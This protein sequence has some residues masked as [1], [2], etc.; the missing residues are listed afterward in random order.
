MKT[1]PS[2][3]FTAA[4]LACLTLT[5]AALGQGAAV[6]MDPS[7]T[8]KPEKVILSAGHGAELEFYRS[9]WQAMKV[10]TPAGKEINVTDLFFYTTQV[11][12][13]PD[14]SAYWTDPER[15]DKELTFRSGTAGGD[16]AA[17]EITG[18]RGPL[19]KSVN[20]AIYPDDPAVYVVSRLSAGEAVQI[21]GDPQLAYFGL[22][23]QDLRSPTDVFVDGENKTHIFD[24]EVTARGKSFLYTYFPGL[25]MCLAIL[26]LPKEKQSIRVDSPL[27]YLNRLGN[28]G[29]WGRE[30]R[31]FG[32]GGHELKPGEEIDLRYVIYWNDGD[33]LDEVKSLAGRLQSGALDDKFPETVGGN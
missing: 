23:P 14:L 28:R 29:D 5:Q 30:F 24:E 10:R 21:E 27:E 18:Q 7:G 31:V 8:D 16:G 25:D 13:D 32:L 9:L 3:G 2:T 4:L 20:A 33:R 11:T 22:P 19:N 17:V 26:A 15:W 12:E 1:H 6:T